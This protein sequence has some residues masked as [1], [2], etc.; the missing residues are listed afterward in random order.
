MDAAA[1]EAAQRAAEECAV[2]GIPTE[3]ITRRAEYVYDHKPGL[4]P[5]ERKLDSP[6]SAGGSPC[7]HHPVLSLSPLE[8]PSEVALF[9]QTLLC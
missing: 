7:S 2:S 1:L 3:V 8:R 9:R 6:S 5:G 4:V